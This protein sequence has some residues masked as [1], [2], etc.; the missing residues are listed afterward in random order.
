MKIYTSK[1]RPVKASARRNVRN[2]NTRMIKAGEDELLEGPGEDFEMMG[3]E[4]T[5]APEATELMFEVEDVADLVAEITDQ[6]VQVEADEDTV[7]FTVGE[8]VYTVEAE[9]DE[10]ILESR[11]ARRGRAIKANTARKPMGKVVRRMPRR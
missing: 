2:R 1:K 3:G 7:E 11:R 8:D 5:I 6:P 10:E 9:G 4:V